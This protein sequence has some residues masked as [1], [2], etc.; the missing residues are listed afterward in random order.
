[1]RIGVVAPIDIGAFVS[2]FEYESDKLLLEK[3][4]VYNTAPA[5]TTLVK[6]FITAGHKVVV[7]TTCNNNIECKSDKIDI[8]ATVRCDKYPQKYLWGIYDNARCLKHLISCHINDVDVLHAHWTYEFAFSAKSFTNFVPVFCTIRDYAPYI[9][10][11]VSLKDKITWTIRRLMN[12]QVLRTK[13]VHFVAN[14]PYTS[15]MI[16]KG[17]SVDTIIIPNS[18]TNS[19]FDVPCSSEPSGINI[20]CITSN[21]NIRKNIVALIKAFHLFYEKHPSAHLSIIGPYE[22][23]RPEEMDR[24][25]LNGW[26]TNVSFL[27]V[28]KHNELLHYI[29]ECNIFVSPSLEESFGN[30]F[31][32]CMSRKR[33]VIGGL[34]SGAVPYVLK[35][36]EA[37]YL[38][39]V[40]NPEAIKNAIDEAVEHPDV[41]IKK[42]MNA[43]DYVRKTFSEEVVMTLYISLFD[44]IVSNR[45]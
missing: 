28:K 14:S 26:L 23:I 9:W 24:W 18:I 12:W 10:S 37:G 29:D 2:F 7:F 22:Q 40:S 34:F 21:F 44:S 45:S 39:D 25:Q 43:Y 6:S 41:R 32:E 33:T 19:F 35:N 42:V 31:I 5:V 17:F 38:C 3:W 8:Y 11:I 30:T 1:M 20:L 16:K 27:G 15:E 36:G 13:N 4:R